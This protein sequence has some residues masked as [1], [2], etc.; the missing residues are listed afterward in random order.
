MHGGDSP[1]YS[2]PTLLDFL[3]LRSQCD[4]DPQIQGLFDAGYLLGRAKEDHVF[5]DPSA[6]HDTMLWGS[7]VILPAS[8]PECCVWTTA[9]NNLGLI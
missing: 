4:E 1:V 7:L 5:I 2:L 3:T 8:S 9:Q 6:L